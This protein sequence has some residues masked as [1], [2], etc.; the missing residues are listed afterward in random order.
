MQPRFYEKKQRIIFCALLIIF[1]AWGGMFLSL[2]AKPGY[3]YMHWRSDLTDIYVPLLKENL[4][5]LKNPLWFKQYI[6]GY[7]MRFIFLTETVTVISILYVIYF[8]GDYIHK[9]EF[10][11]SKWANPYAVCK[12]LRDKNVS[13]NKIYKETV[14]RRKS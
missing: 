9:K 10:G 11:T 7:T 3:D 12:A 14:I 1:A 4:Y 5:G 2:A 8:Q 13:E 6:N